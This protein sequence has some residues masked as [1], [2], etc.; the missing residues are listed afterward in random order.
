MMTT[1]SPMAAS[2]AAEPDRPHW[3]QPA[4]TAGHYSGRA[5]RSTA[6]ACKS[7]SSPRSRMTREA[8]YATGR[9]G[10]L[11]AR[12]MHPP[13]FRR[14]LLGGA[15]ESALD[16]PVSHHRQDGKDNG[17]ENENLQAQIADGGARP[18]T[19]RASDHDGKQ[20]E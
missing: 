12:S 17:Q 10:L 20:N 16:E 15:P 19:F 14:P 8:G 11:L 3:C 2:A 4:G 6:Q 9:D 18:P 5:A 7:R 1:S 13:I